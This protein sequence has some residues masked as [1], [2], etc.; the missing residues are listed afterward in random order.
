MYSWKFL[1][2]ES[3]AKVCILT[4]MI[5][6]RNLK[7]LAPTGQAMPLQHTYIQSG[8]I[9]QTERS[10]CRPDGQIMVWIVTVQFSCFITVLFPKCA[11]LLWKV[12]KDS[13][14]ALMMN[15]DVWQKSIVCTGKLSQIAIYLQTQEI[16]L[17]DNTVLYYTVIPLYILKGL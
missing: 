8:R 15:H 5:N 13:I 9:A 1:Q 14:L 2:E 12:L 10:S 4:Q 16:V 3:L 6:Y 17:L 11:F 7:C